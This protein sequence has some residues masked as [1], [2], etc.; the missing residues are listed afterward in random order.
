MLSLTRRCAPWLMNAQI[1]LNEFERFEDPR[2]EMRFGMEKARQQPNTIH[3][4]LRDR[5]TTDYR[6]TVDLTE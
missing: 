3:G 4:F 1:L 6:Q 2:I 5:G